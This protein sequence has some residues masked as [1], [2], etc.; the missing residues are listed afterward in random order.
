[1]NASAAEFIAEEINGQ[2]I[3]TFK[4]RKKDKDARKKRDTRT[5]SGSESEIEPENRRQ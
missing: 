4:I 2:K 3:P 1:M 5:D